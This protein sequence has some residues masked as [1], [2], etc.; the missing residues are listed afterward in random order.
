M[1]P[2]NKLISG[3]QC[4]WPLY[5]PPPRISL[6]LFQF[7]FSPSLET[8]FASS[9]EDSLLSLVLS[10]NPHISGFKHS[11]ANVGQLMSFAIK[12]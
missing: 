7:F 5:C 11:P 9:G 1:E 4:E 12:G 6:E 8:F 10:L 2:V 3:S